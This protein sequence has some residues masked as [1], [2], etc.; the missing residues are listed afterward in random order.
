MLLSEEAV[1]LPPHDFSRQQNVKVCLLICSENKDYQL[2]DHI[3]RSISVDS[4]SDETL[5]QGTRRLRQK[6]KF[7]FGINKV[8]LSIVSIVSTFNRSV[9]YGAISHVG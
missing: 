7:P 2:Y 1:V 9:L 5:N 8:Q 6:Y 3:S 4:P